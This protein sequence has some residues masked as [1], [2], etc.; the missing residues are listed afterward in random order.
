MSKMNKLCDMLA[1]CKIS[2]IGQYD[3]ALEARKEAEQEVKS[4]YNPTSSKYHSKLE[5]V[6]QKFE[7]DVE[8]AK[9][10]ILDIANKEFS[11]V[12]SEVMEYAQ[13]IDVK[14]LE[15]LNALDGVTLDKNAVTA[16]LYKYDGAA[17]KSYCV[18]QKLAEMTEKVG[19]PRWCVNDSATIED[20]IGVL[21]SL[22]NQLDKLLEEY[23]GELEGHTENISIL[24]SSGVLD[25]ARKMY[26]KGGVV[27]NATEGVHRQAIT[28]IKDAKGTLVKSRMA[29]A[30]MGILPTEE[31]TDLFLHLRR[32]GELEERHTRFSKNAEEIQAFADL[33][34]TKFEQT[35]KE[36]GSLLKMNRTLSTDDRKEPLQ[37]ALNANKDNPF[38][39]YILKKEMDDE[40]YETVIG[41]PDSIASLIKSASEACMA[42]GGR[43]S[44]TNTVNN[45]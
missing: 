15:E 4:T 21:D 5:E 2:Y 37:D 12:Y 26:S 3:R 38:F 27:M 25:N 6:Q 13:N 14:T 29:E 36:V 9:R 32:Q 40:E 45:A 44:G 17:A 34:G 10:S 7:E 33:N 8:K 35:E 31:K 19:L 28:L 1:A 22:G 20:K 24:F 39:E 18:A 16:L 23:S 11:E 41:Q 43:T 30:L 42:A